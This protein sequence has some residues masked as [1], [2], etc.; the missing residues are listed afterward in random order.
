MVD[1]GKG[2]VAFLQKPFLPEDLT[3]ALRQLSRPLPT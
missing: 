1:E 3:S 2:V